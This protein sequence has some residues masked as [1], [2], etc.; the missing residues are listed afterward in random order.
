MASYDNNKPNVICC[1]N[2]ADS[3]GST[4]VEAI[5]IQKLYVYA[6]LT[7]CTLLNGRKG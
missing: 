7:I 4:A 6:R 5:T 1:I 2:L 3:L